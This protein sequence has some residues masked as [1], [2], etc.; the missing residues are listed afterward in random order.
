VVYGNPETTTGGNAL[1]F[2]ASVRL[3]IRKTGVVKNGE[4]VVGNKT[5]VKVVKNK[6]APPFRECEFEILYGVGVLAAAEIVDLASEAGLIEKS[7]AYYSGTAIASPRAATRLASTSMS[8][9]SWPPSCAT[10]WSR[11]ARR[12]TRDSAHRFL[13]RRARVRR[14]SFRTFGPLPW[15]S[16]DRPIAPRMRSQAATTVCHA[17]AHDALAYARRQPETTLLYKTLQ[18][19]WLGFRATIEGEG[20][21]AMQGLRAWQAREPLVQAP[22]LLP[23][24]PRS[25]NGVGILTGSAQ[26]KHA[27]ADESEP[28]RR[29]RHEVLAIRTNQEPPGRPLSS[30]GKP[31]M[32]REERTRPSRDPPNAMSWFNDTRVGRKLAVFGAGATMS[33]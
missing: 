24:L 7:G 13:Q 33:L 12:R 23:E 15:M 3:D 6:V 8:I 19:H 1:R 10:S 21:G 5:R 16:S 28:R 18:T 29:I 26:T 25:P 30:V 31:P 11:F 9:P 2:Y 22:W 4:Q 32:M 20:A 17:P 27:A 14:R